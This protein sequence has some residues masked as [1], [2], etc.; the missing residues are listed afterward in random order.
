MLEVGDAI[1]DDSLVLQLR[2]RFGSGA[3]EPAPAV[4]LAVSND[5]GAAEN[6]Q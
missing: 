6:H 2:E 1:H 3:A 5:W 4:Q